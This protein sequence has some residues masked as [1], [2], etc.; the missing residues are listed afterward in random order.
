MPQP[1]RHD[2]L[3][4]ATKRDYAGAGPSPIS[5]GQSLTE[6]VAEPSAVLVKEIEGLKPTP[7]EA[8]NAS[9]RSAAAEEL[10]ARKKWSTDIETFRGAA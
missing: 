2:L 3:S 9:R 6:L 7:I 10:E 1:E 5:T 8:P 4:K